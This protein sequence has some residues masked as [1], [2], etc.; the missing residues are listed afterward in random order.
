[1]FGLDWQKFALVG[2]AVLIVGLLLGG[3]GIWGGYSYAW[4]KATAENLERERELTRQLN[5]ANTK[6][7][8][9]EK[10]HA[11]TVADLRAQFQLESGIEKTK[12]QATI[13]DLRTGNKRL[14]L[15]VSNCNATGPSTP[16]VTPAGT[17]G[18]GT[19]EL[20]GEASA[21]LWGIAADADGAARQL[22]KLQEWALSAVKL[23]GAPK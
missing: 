3:F 18:A 4:K 7:R 9:M 15:A 23:C 14:R 13:T 22:T 16:G 10:D 6:N 2:V 17:D 19:A 12:D 21:S 5:E 8:T 20:S 11:Q 1:M